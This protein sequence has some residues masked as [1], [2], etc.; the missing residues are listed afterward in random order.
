[1]K[2]SQSAPYCLIIETCPTS[3]LDV[4]MFNHSSRPIRSSIKKISAFLQSSEG[5]TISSLPNIFNSF[6]SLTADH[7][8]HCHKI[9]SNQNI[10]LHLERLHSCALSPST[11]LLSSER[12]KKFS[13]IER[14]VKA[15]LSSVQFTFTLKIDWK[16]SDGFPHFSSFERSGNCVK[17]GSCHALDVRFHHPS[18]HFFTSSF[19]E[20]DLLED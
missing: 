9:G 18:Q 1:M 3:I 4:Y 13:S 5:M 7:L 6:P 14:N 11:T 10:L 8:H 16:K 17:R 12:V 15:G 19:D 20:E 2:N